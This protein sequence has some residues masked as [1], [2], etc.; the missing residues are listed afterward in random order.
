MLKLNIAAIV[1]NIGEYAG[2]KHNLNIKETLR[3][4]GIYVDLR[5]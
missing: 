5:N 3:T 2:F 4:M 1:E